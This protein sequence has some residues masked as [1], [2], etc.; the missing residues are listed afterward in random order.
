MPGQKRI[1]DGLSIDLT[2]FTASFSFFLCSPAIQRCFSGFIPL[3][4]HLLHPPCLP[5]TLPSLHHDALLP[6]PPS[7]FPL[8]SSS[9]PFPHFP[10]LSLCHV[11]PHPALCHCLS[12]CFTSSLLHKMKPEHGEHDKQAPFRRIPGVTVPFSFYRHG[13]AGF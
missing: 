1:P 8:V 5:L 10:S 11:P 3:F 13:N 7:Y 4:F 9:R 6:P 2:P 12:C